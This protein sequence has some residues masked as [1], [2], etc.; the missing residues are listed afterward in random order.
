M[1]TQHPI[2]ERLLQ[3]E[4]QTLS[5][6]A[7]A[8]PAPIAPAFAASGRFAAD[9]LTLH[10][11][12]F[13]ALKRPLDASA[14]ERLRMLSQDARFG[15]REH[16]LLD[17]DVR[18]TGEI[19]ADL[20]HLTWPE[21]SRDALCREISALLGSGPLQARL[22]NLLVYGPGDFFKPHQDTE[23]HDGMVGT[24]VLVWPSAHLGGGL[25]VRHGSGDWRF[26]SQQLG[27]VD[28]R[29]AAFFADCR[30]EVLPVQEGWR[31]VLTFDLV[32]RPD[33]RPLTGSVPADAGLVAALRA[34]C[35]P[36]HDDERQPDPW[37][38]L[39][40]HEYS[41][42]GLRWHL[43]KGADRDR[44]SRLRA[45]ARALGLVLHLA[46]VEV[47][48]TWSA[49]F[50]SSGWHRRRGEPDPEPEPG[51]LMELRRPA[52]RKALAPQSPPMM[53]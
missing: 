4:S 14:A 11:E 5:S 13:G 39:L 48:E 16:T 12:G 36:E 37:V 52:S 31:V 41:E 26:A 2:L 8:T 49:D 43:L 47:H 38:L 7:G 42:R 10:V 18:R 20:L 32:A 6:G 3:L 51:E 45:A 1:L 23:K 29:W 17:P 33:E 50:E 9:D 28:L 21:A 30:H 46:L 53:A 22:H 25:C 15:L 35:L 34:Q 19:A 44:V 40:D 27:G 24:L